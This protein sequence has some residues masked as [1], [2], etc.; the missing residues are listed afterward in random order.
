MENATK[1]LLIAASVLIVIV[2]I[3]VG[4]KLLS[5]TS[6]V[7]D[8]VDSVSGTMASSVFNSQ[9][10]TYFSKSTS[11]KQAKALISKIIA[12]NASIGGNSI[13][14]DKHHIVVNYKNKSGNYINPYGATGGGHK[15]TPSQLQ[16]ISFDISDTQNYIINATGGCTTQG[17]LAGYYNGY[18][19]CITIQETN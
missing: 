10:T 17:C 15:W 6:G 4:I 12:N 1:A 14:A 9:F 2:L 16:A 8:Q 19:F 11:G 5:S 13:S 7:S 18:V 3:S